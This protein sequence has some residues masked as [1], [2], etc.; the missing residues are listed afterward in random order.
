MY[1]CV[2][3]IKVVLVNVGDLRLIDVDLGMDK[4]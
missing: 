2:D 1:R 4:C 3:N